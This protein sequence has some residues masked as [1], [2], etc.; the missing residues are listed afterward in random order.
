[1]SPD[2]PALRGLLESI[3]LALTAPEPVHHG[4]DDLHLAT[5]KAQTFM[6][7]LAVRCLLDGPLDNVAIQNYARLLRNQDIP[8]SYAVAS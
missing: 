5:L 4:D 6:V 2:T 7:R 3:D 8:V 1:M